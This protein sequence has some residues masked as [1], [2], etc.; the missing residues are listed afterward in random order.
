MPSGLLI[1][2]GVIG[3]IAA[4][5]DAASIG[6]ASVKAT[7][8]YSEIYCTGELLKTVQL[9]NIYSDSKT[10]VDLQQI[11]DPEITLANFYELMKETNNKP[12]KSQLTQYVNENF[13]ASNE[14]VNWTLSDWT[15]NPSILQR[16]QEPKYYEWVKDLNEIWKKL[17]RKVNPEVAR[18]PDRH[19]LIYVPNGLIIPGGRFKEFYYWDSY[20]VIEGLLLSDMYQ[21]AR[22][23]IDNF[24][25]M[26]Q[27]YGFIP[28]GGRI[29]YLMRS[30]PP[31][32]HLMVSKYLDFT[33]DYDYLRKVIPTLESEF[34]FWQQK[35]MIDVKKDGRTYKMGH[36]A[37][38]STRPRPESYREDYEQ[39]QLLP[40]K[41]RDFFYNNIKAGAESGWD[42]SNRWCIADNNNRTLSLLNIS[43]QHIIPVDLNAIL[44]QNARLLGEFHSLL[45]NNA[46]SQYYHKVASQL[47][48]AID[49][50]LWNEEEGTWL[51]Y[52]MKNAKP[53]HAFYP[54]NLAPLYTRSYNRLQ[55]ERYALSIVKYLKTQNI[56]TFLGG[57]PTSLNY[58][59]EQWDFPNAWPP[60]QSFI[61]MGLYWTGVE[62]AVNFAHELAF[63][64]LGSN[65]AG[66]VE[67]KEMF[68]KYD[69]LTPGKSGGGGE[70]DVQSGFGWT[71]GVVLEFLNTFPN[72]KVKEISYINDINTEIRQ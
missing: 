21:T 24:L 55:R 31:L 58:T 12:T 49:N 28:N 69:S 4:L 18:Q 29:Y 35:R 39:A 70:Y 11:N 59:G 47:Q 36:Y 41:S 56:D 48:M 40:E 33:G 38:N 63:R 5:T 45:G 26:V 53:R 64:W 68:E 51:D 46:K 71:N 61:V 1:A 16:I 30:Q 13:V 66:Y 14:L 23:M 43:T 32:I 9:S 34:A 20:W 42:F 2:V 60:L 7:D 8:C 37:V 72:I 10:F 25:Y 3:L 17:A 15:N 67:Y 22:G 27:K 57:T 50:V 6:H 52:D 44:Q 54:S 62:E 65:Y 19:S